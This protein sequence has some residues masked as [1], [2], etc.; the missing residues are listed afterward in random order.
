MA[1]GQSDHALQ[2]CL[3]E[4]Y[5]SVGKAIVG[6]GSQ[7]RGASSPLQITSCIIP[8]HSSISQPVESLILDIEDG[9]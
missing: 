6:T 3:R 8:G 2:P 5:A 9:L 7:V 1:E 4:K